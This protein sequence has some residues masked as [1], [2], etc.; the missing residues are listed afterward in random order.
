MI[1]VR[2]KIDSAFQAH[3]KNSI[4]DTYLLCPAGVGL[5]LNVDTSTTTCEIIF[6]PKSVLPLRFLI[7]GNRNTFLQIAEARLPRVSLDY[8]PHHHPNSH[9]VPVILSPAFLLLS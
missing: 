6:S 9:R 1:V 4:S 2:M 8:S 7:L 5:H 3:S